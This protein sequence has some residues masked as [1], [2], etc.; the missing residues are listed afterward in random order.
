M[1]R[2]LPTVRAIVRIGS[3]TV[4]DL[5]DSANLYLTDMQARWYEGVLHDVNYNNTVAERLAEAADT[6]PCLYRSVAGAKA[7]RPLAVVD[8]G[9]AT[10][11]E[12]VRKLRLMAGVA[13]VTRYIAID[14]NSR[15]LSKVR[16]GVHRDLGIEVTTVEAKFETLDR[17]IIERPTQGEILLIFGST[18]MNYEPDV[19]IS[20]LGR[21][22]SPGI[23]IS[24]ETLLRN[25]VHTLAAGYHSP[26]VE[27]F[28]FGP[29]WLVGGRR[30][31]FDF[32]AVESLDR[33]SLQFVAKS[34]V[35][36][37][38]PEIPA[39]RLG[40][41][42]QTCFS[43]R[44]TLSEHKAEFCRVVS[45]CETAVINDTVAGSL[46]EVKMR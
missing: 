23:F 9:P 26:A 32:R 11:E 3:Q 34:D 30:D 28:V 45:R 14:V 15:L 44:P 8:C 41:I 35:R 38:H 16:A 13:K 43:R 37:R 46:G 21:L 6:I 7:R 20:L 12:S 5:A 31:A 2:P 1:L 22:S 17:N 25:G 36:L 33:V 29:L 27:T 18:A 42:V 39:L 40:D 4:V 10:A 24:V 19:L